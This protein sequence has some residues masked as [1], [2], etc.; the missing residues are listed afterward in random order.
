MKRGSDRQRVERASATLM[1][2]PT[3]LLVVGCG[4]TEQVDER[5]ID[6]LESGLAAHEAAVDHASVYQGI[7]EGEL[8]YT[9]GLDRHDETLI[10][11]PFWAEAVISYGQARSRSGLGRW[12]NELHAAR[13]AHQHHVTALTINL[14][15][16]MALEEG[17]I[18]FSADPQRDTQFDTVGTPTPGRVVAGSFATLGTGRYVN[19]YE[20]REGVWKMVDH[21]YVNDLSV[22]LQTVDLCASAC[23]GRWDPS[24]ISYLRPLESLSVE[25]RQQRAEAGTKPRAAGKPTG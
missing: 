24:D 5:E 2:I 20:R 1:L 23:L 13:A 18:L 15:G 22:R 6:A 25:E 19:R 14:E 16:D 9:R 8:T 3:L 10:E 17:Y 4:W 7:L 11:A 12:A 21:K